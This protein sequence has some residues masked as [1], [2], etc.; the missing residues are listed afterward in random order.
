[1]TRF[2]ERPPYW[3]LPYRKFKEQK[4]KELRAVIKAYEKFRLGCAYV[5][6]F[7]SNAKNLAESLEGWK[8][9]MNLKNWGR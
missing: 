7:H 2:T 8:D 5:P 3:N 6:G 1:M 4:R 9:S